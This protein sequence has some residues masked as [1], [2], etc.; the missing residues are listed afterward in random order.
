MARDDCPMKHLV[1]EH[2]AGRIHPDRE[3]AL[4][5]HL[6]WCKTCTDYYERRLVLERLDPAGRGPFER[7]AKGLGIP[8]H[9]RRSPRLRV[10][11][12]AAM[13]AGLALF[14]LLPAVGRLLAPRGD[15]TMH[16]R[17]SMPSAAVDRIWIYRP[18]PGDEEQ[19]VSGM[20]DRED[21]LAFKYSTSH[22][23]LMIFAK[24]E[25]GRVYWYYPEWTDPG[26]NPIAVDVTPGPGVV[27][28]PDVIR[29]D[30]RGTS[31]RLHALFLDSPLDVR[32]VESALAEGRLDA[33]VAAH[34][35]S[36]QVVTLRLGGGR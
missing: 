28:L 8:T 6:P 20:I 23:Y 12:P 27:A 19:P 33:L 16:P 9:E 31:L 25:T 36:H 11:V 5:A 3:R 10:L 7:L 17:G 13:A 29:H 24:D 18:A 14:L 21:G 26:A 15:A 30:Y 4:R 32:A 34:R 1:D 2:F 22:Q 35:G